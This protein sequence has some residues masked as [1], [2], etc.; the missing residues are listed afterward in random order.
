MYI[1]L[2]LKPT[3]VVSSPLAAEL[4]LKTHDANFSSRPKSESSELLSYGSKG[5]AFSEYGPYWRSM[6]RL[7]TLEL[8]CPAKIEGFAGMRREEVG[9]MVG[10]LRA[11]HGELVDMSDEVAR[12]VE[13][14]SCRMVFGKRFGNRGLDVKGTVKEALELAGALN[15]TDFLPFLAPFDIQ[16][17]TRRLKET[18]KTLDK[19]F[20]E[21]INEHEHNE[22]TSQTQD[23]DFVDVM[24]SLKNAS[25]CTTDE[26]S[27]TIERENIKAIILD[28]IVGSF[29]TTAVSLEWAMS[30]LLKNPKVMKKLQEELNNV[31]G[32]NKTVEEADLGKLEYLDM[33]IKESQRLH[34]VAPFLIPRI[35]I[36]DITIDGFFIPK[37]SH[38]L[39]NSWTL[40][41]NTKAWGNSADEFIPERFI[42]S[43]IDFKGKHFQFLPFGSGRRSCPGT[44]LG[45]I[46]IRLVLAQLVHCF[47]WELP[48]GISAS[49]MDMNEKFGLALSRA[50]HLCAIPTYRLH[51][52]TV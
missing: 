15:V 7:C 41:R 6:R 26:I 17:F 2:G 12:V 28:M 38:I 22:S 40:G 29:D 34:P 14:M 30:E 20:E 27:Y 19:I 51:N 42:G 1:Q 47:N 8:L 25:S 50:E 32:E 35:C 18:N 49:E 11:K 10:R 13:D 23:K 21:I 43:E 31:I 44:N 33:V 16:G 46:S 4:F 45:L 3:I 39:V 52:K 9:R 5:L 37:N 36:E 48:K 24:L